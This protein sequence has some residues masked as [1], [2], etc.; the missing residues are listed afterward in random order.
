MPFTMTDPRPIAFFDM[1]AQ[2]RL[3]RAEIDRRVAAVL[4]SGRFVQGPE[5]EEL[6]IQL[7][8]F[9]GAQHCVGVSSGTD[10]LQ[11]AMMA[12]GI[13]R[14]DAVF[15]PAFTYTATAEVPLV[16]G[17]TPVFVD[18]DPATFNIDLADLEHRIALVEKEG[19]LRPRAV[20]GVDLYG[21]PADWPAIR[22]LCAAKGMFT[23]DDAAQAFGGSLDNRRLGVHADATALSFYP[24]KT[25][26]CY[27]D[28]GALLTD[29][30]ERA[31]LYRSLRTH[32]E[33]KT[34]YEVLRTGMN[35]RLD[36]IQAAILLAKLPLLEGEL[37]ARN[38]TAAIYGHRLAG[39]VGVPAVPAG[40]VSAWGI[41]SILLQ[42]A[43]Q[44]A[45]VQAAM[46]NAGVPSAI[47]YPRPLHRQPAYAQHHAG[48]IAGGPPPL[49][50]SEDLCQ[51]VLSLPM[52]GYLDESQAARVCDAVLSGL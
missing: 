4:D 12:E 50:V 49:P 33:G 32:G 36:T 25:L 17:A 39:R 19:R 30:A 41:Y 9:A 23:L 47:Y 51:R 44:R 29:S 42:D 16:L 15:L 27:G 31:D 43:A 6:E 7:A 26:G 10:A 20:V 37:V 13:G 40:S 28:G 45:A 11:I 21:L 5:V 48:A 18:V 1:Q 22:A 14:G 52:H 8:A 24:T 3:I 35:G 34:R 46:Q 2:Q 38:R